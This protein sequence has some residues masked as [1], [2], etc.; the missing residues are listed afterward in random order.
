MI[1]VIEAKEISIDFIEPWRCD[2]CGYL[3][4]NID[5]NGYPAPGAPIGMKIKGESTR[6]C[7]LC[8]DMYVTVLKSNHFKEQHKSWLQ[9]QQYKTK[10]K[11]GGNYLDKKE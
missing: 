2:N 1:L 5:K 9:T 10:L 8:C 7:S 6:V 4:Y 3:M 11:L